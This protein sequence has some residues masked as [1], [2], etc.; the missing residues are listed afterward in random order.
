MPNIKQARDVYGMDGAADAVIYIMQ[1]Q[2]VVPDPTAG[3][4]IG[5][6]V[7]ARIDHGRW[8]GDCNLNDAVNVRV[9]P[10]AQY[11]DEADLRFFCITCHN[12]EIGGRW[13]TVVFPADIEATEAPLLALPATEQNWTSEA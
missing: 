13:R 2:Q 1:A 10:N 4:P 8:I 9:C 12:A 3:D 5:P 6:N 11:V 7:V